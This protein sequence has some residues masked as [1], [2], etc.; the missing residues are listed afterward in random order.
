M[1]NGLQIKK[2][3]EILRFF[4]AVAPAITGAMQIT[5]SRQQSFF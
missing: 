3:Q 5:T 4:I 2:P 1:L